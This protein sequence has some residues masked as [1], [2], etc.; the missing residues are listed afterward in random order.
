MKKR[1]VVTFVAIFFLVPHAF[2]QDIQSLN[3]QTTKEGIIESLT[4]A[5]KPKTKTRSLGT[6][7]RI[8]VAGF[9]DNQVIRQEIEISEEDL[10]PSVNMKIEFD[11]NSYI[12]RPESYPLLEELGQALTSEDLR[13]QT[14][15]VKGHTDSDG[16][17]EYNLNLSLNRAKAVQYY[18]VGQFKIPETRL[19]VLGYGPALP[20]VQEYDSADKQINRRVEIAVDLN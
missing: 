12:I 1:I 4:A 10:R 19:K 9:E 11:V 3:F 2:A 16:S 17:I 8:I 6:K 14:I 13:P 18:L 7:T 5:P 20:L 15:L